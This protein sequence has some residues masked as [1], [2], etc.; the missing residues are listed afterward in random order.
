MYTHTHFVVLCVSFNYIKF[1]IMSFWIFVPYRLCSPLFSPV[2]WSALWKVRT[3]LL[4][5]I[6]AATFYG[7]SV[8][9]NNPVSEALKSSFD[10]L[11]WSLLLTLFVFT[12]WAHALCTLC[13]PGKLQGSC[14]IDQVHIVGDFVLRS[15]AKLQQPALCKR[16]GKEFRMV[17]DTRDLAAR[18]PNTKLR[19]CVVFY[20]F[21]FH[22]S[23]S[24]RQFF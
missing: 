3:L 9:W 7:M 19:V 11:S 15:E 21:L 13:S 8:S 14:L 24:A 16:R 6:S 1:S 5:I 10:L 12:V 2:W 4:G 22:R 18:T 23:N 20:L 17:P